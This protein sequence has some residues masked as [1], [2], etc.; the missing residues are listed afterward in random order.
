MRT[1]ATRQNVSFP[2]SSSA[3][4]SRRSDPGL[5][6]SPKMFPMISSLSPGWLP[7][8]WCCN[9][10][11]TAAS[12][13]RSRQEINMSKNTEP[14]FT[15]NNFNHPDDLLEAAARPTLRLALRCDWVKGYEDRDDLDDPDSWD[16]LNEAP[17]IL[18]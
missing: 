11:R 10:R 14:K 13:C 17:E 2:V 4:S 5:V 6:G 9:V 1:R 3:G 12:F 16:S 15:S 8:L 7:K 18:M